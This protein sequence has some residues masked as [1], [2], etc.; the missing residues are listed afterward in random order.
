MVC[1]VRRN[2]KMCSLQQQCTALVGYHALER[3]IFTCTSM[4][5]RLT[6]ASPCRRKQQHSGEANPNSQSS[7]AP[8][9][10]ARLRQS[11]V[12]RISFRQDLQNG[13]SVCQIQPRS[14][15]VVCLLPGVK[16]LRRMSQRSGCENN[17]GAIAPRK[18]LRGIPTRFGHVAVNLASIDVLDNE[19][20]SLSA[21]AHHEGGLTQQSFPRNAR[22]SRKKSK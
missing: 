15:P 5:P 22:C 17:P 8:S 11:E 16:E 3:L 10:R 19:I 21:F 18:R 7:K 2:Q 9:W 1:C 6:D 4:S 12:P 13:A 20:D 14:S